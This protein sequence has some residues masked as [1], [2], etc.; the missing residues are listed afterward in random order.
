MSDR[1][2]GDPDLEPLDAIYDALDDGEPEL[3]LE[4]ARA[5]I[6]AGAEHD[7]VLHLLCGVALLELDDAEAAATALARA[8]AID[9]DDAESRAYLAEA[10]FRCC[11]FE[12]AERE[13]RAALRS[14]GALPLAHWILGLALERRGLMEEADAEFARASRE[15]PEDFRAPVR[16]SQDEFERHLKAA[17]AALPPLFREPLREVSVTVDDLP[18]LE[19]LT[20][21]EPPLDPELLGLFLGMART[22]RTVFSPGGELPPRIVLFKRN[23]ERAAEDADDLREEIGIT[24]RHELAHYLGLDEEEIESAGHG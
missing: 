12:P 20:A 3:A 8:C 16:F 7:P 9:P 1:L 19:V 21:D 14:D 2:P 15:A 22:E 23:L 13:S 4:R 18:S 10:H 24:V 6:D 5:A 11:R 17:I